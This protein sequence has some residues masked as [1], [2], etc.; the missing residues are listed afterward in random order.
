MIKPLPFTLLAGATLLSAC[1]GGST[2]NAVAIFD[3]SG[4]LSIAELNEFGEF[5][6][7]QSE[8]IAEGDIT[9]LSEA[10]LIAQGSATYNGYMV[11]GIPVTEDAIVGRTNVTA[12]FTDGGSVT[13]SVTDMQIFPGTYID[14]EVGPDEEIAFEPLASDIE[15]YDVAG[16]LTLSD[17]TISTTDGFGIM[18]IGLD[19]D[20]TIPVAATQTESAE[21]Y[22]ISGEFEAGLLTDE[23]FVGEGEVIADGDDDMFGV[24]I[25]MIAR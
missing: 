9:G 1:G 18:T 10:D 8:A 24:E 17:G 2:S 22:T 3:N 12:T 14:E 7:N 25:L 5:S 11:A 19:G 13:G 15:R 23:T 4:V 20:V 16:T 21:T 6:F